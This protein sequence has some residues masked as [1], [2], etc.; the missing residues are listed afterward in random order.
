MSK[1]KNIAL[2]LLLVIC[3]RTVKVFFCCIQRSIDT[4][5]APHMPFVSAFKIP[6]PLLEN[7]FAT[8]EQP[9]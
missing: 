6:E 4:Q 1:G 3:A 8:L 2:N 5:N 9:L 7:T